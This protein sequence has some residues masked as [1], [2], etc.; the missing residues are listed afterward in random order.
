MKT[1]FNFYKIA[2]LN[3]VI[4][5]LPSSQDI[6]DYI[7]TVP[8][9]QKTIAIKILKQN[10]RLTKQLLVQKIQELSIPK[11][12][13]PYLGIQ[14]NIL[15]GNGL[16]NELQ[17]WVLVNLRKSRG[18]FALQDWMI[19]SNINQYRKVHQ[20]MPPAW[21]RSFQSVKQMIR[22]HGLSDWRNANP[23]VNL[24][25]INIFQAQELVREWHQSIKNGNKNLQYQQNNPVYIF[26]SPDYQKN[27]F[28]NGWTIQQIKTQNDLIVQGN[29]M[30]HCVSD[31]FQAV[32]S[33]ESRI[34]SLR[35][36][37]NQP[38][39]TIQTDSDITDFNQI[40]GKSNS[41]PKKQYMYL[42]VEWIKSLGI[43]PI[44]NAIPEPIDLLQNFNGETDSLQLFLKHIQKHIN[45]QK[46]MFG[47][48][49]VTFGGN[50]GDLLLK[51]LQILQD[52]HPQSSRNKDEPKYNPNHGEILAKQVVDL[53]IYGGKQQTLNFWRELNIHNA[54]AHQDLQ[55]PDIF[56]DKVFDRD[57]F[58]SD[59]QYFEAIHNAQGQQSD[60]QYD[61]YTYDTLPL[62]FY[63]NLNAQI[64]KRQSKGQIPAT[65]QEL[66]T[67]V[68]QQNPVKQASKNWYKRANYQEVP[69][70]LLFKITNQGKPYHDVV[71]DLGLLP[72]SFKKSAGYNCLGMVSDNLM[73]DLNYN[74]ILDDRNSPFRKDYMTIQAYN[75]FP[76]DTKKFSNKI[77]MFSVPQQL[78]KSKVL[79]QLSDFTFQ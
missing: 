29:K 32:D 17:T 64:V 72:Q 2:Q 74:K 70:G 59:Q 6:K 14:R 67:M 66:Q 53:A 45:H 8:D 42:V 34:F 48:D 73:N 79:K 41:E 52:D 75:L 23:N 65:I 3:K 21:R 24:S 15:P 18:G 50:W 5:S 62:G 31:Y 57:H 43:T 47:Q 78:L 28:S 16:S 68:N 26:K 30:D 12:L 49:L 38:H 77:Q 22:T 7:T 9:S 54:T 13:D 51:C 27:L 46:G 1:L 61:E 33:G 55:M 76:N 4:Q 20:A 39:I 11:K 36:Q 63:R 40:F 56:V 25:H 58:Q 60:R 44:G 10:P 37:K 35:D 69:S 19:K 71:I